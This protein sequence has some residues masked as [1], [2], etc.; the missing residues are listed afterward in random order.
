MRKFRKSP[1]AFTLVE[2][3]VIIIII[4]I[5]I[6]G[7][8]TADAL[9]KK[10]RLQS[11]Q[12][13][14]K[15]SPITGITG[16]AIWLESSLDTSFLDSESNNS[17]AISTWNDQSVNVNK[18]SISQVGSG[19]VYSNT[20]NYVHAV[21]FSGSTANYLKIADASFLNNT[22]Y[23]IVILEKRQAANA[24]YFLSTTD[25]SDAAD[26]KL[27]LGYASDGVISHS[28]NST[29]YAITPKVSAYADS[30]DKPRLFTFVQDSSAGK[31]T[32]INGTLSASDA[33]NTSQLSGISTLAIGKG[34]TGEIGEIAI[35]TKVLTPQ[36]REAVEDYL[37]KKWTRKINRAS[38]ASCINGIVT[39]SGCSNVCSTSVVV[40][41]AT[42][43]Q[44][45]D[46]DSGTLSCN[47]AGYSGAASV[48]YNCSNGNLNPVGT[49]AAISCTASGTGYSKTG[50]A[51]ATSGSGSFACDTGYTGTKNYTCT[52]AGAATITGGTCTAITCTAPAG[53]GYAAQSNLP[54]A[55]SGSG[56][57]SC[58]TGT[59]TINYTCT[60]TG[61]ATITGGACSA[62]VC[63]GG[64]VDTS[65]SGTTIHMFTSNGTLNCTGAGA[66]SNVQVLVVAGGGGGTTYGGGGGGGGVVY[67]TNHSLSASSYSVTVGGGGARNINV[68]G[69]G[70]SGGN[71]VFDTMTAYG[72]GGGTSGGTP[73]AVSGG[74][75]GGSGRDSGNSVGGAVIAGIA[76]G[77][78]SYGNVGG[79]SQGPGWDGGGGG[80]GAGAVGGLGRGNGSMAGEVGGNGGNGIAI[81]ITSGS[82]ASYP[83]TY[84][85]G[86]GGSVSGNTSTSSGGTGGGGSGGRAGTNGTANTGGG[87]G[88]GTIIG[89]STGGTSI[90]GSG[91][92][93]VVII[94]YLGAQRATGGTVTSAGGYTYHTFTSSGEFKV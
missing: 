7:I 89:V 69:N 49:C 30:T 38:S 32:Y 35:F 3:S 59:G 5:F 13:L 71:S 29:N 78:T 82:T 4:G 10:F 70:G 73:G 1:R 76:A 53:T 27:A 50:L 40:G 84:G 19:P 68:N 63:T 81:S 86:G 77:G 15:S 8:I 58:T 87:G 94:R 66:R 60:S 72:G 93:G 9:I 14:T 37:G 48:S 56:S 26:N 36:D 39:D 43:T 52:S 16:N 57:F 12:A 21:K 79:G 83:G 6:A 46:G 34:Y 25:V 23:T 85:G 20:I 92:S 55:A 31:E 51:Y 67:K 88:G 42:P 75:G 64:T 33:A 47:A 90:V 54:Y 22:D 18:F 45:S 62:A 91:G 28:H 41:V 65:I 80:G 24:G 74:S 11:A 44:V 17:N 61:V 2:L